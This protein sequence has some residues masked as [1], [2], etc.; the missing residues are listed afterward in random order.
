[1]LHLTNDT[2]RIK[3]IH[4]CEAEIKLLSGEGLVNMSWKDLWKLLVLGD[5]V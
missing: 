3:Q 5:F 1:V 2:G 4:Q